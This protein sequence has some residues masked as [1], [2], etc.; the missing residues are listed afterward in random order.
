MKV[1]EELKKIR[2]LRRDKK[3]LEDFLERY[4]NIPGMFE[5]ST[6]EEIQNFGTEL[7]DYLPIIYRWDPD[8]MEYLFLRSDIESLKDLRD[9]YQN[10]E[11]EL[12]RKR[13]ESVPS[14]PIELKQPM[15]TESIVQDEVPVKEVPKVEVIEQPIVKTDI[16]L[17][18]LLD[19]YRQNGLIGEENNAILQTLGAINQLSFGIESLSGSGKS[20]TVDFLMKLLPE[21]AVYKMELS[22]N[23]A[24]M[25]EAETINQAKIICIPELQKAMKSSNPIVVEILKN[26]TEGKDISRK[27]RNQKE[28]T[29]EHY[30]INGDKGVIFTLAVENEFKYDAE[31][32]RRVFILHTDISQKQTDDI[33]R[34]KALKRHAKAVSETYLSQEEIK[35]LEE[36]IGNCLYFPSAEF[37]NPFAD[38]IVEFMPR[39]IRARSYDDYFFDLVD[40]CTKFNHEN[41]VQKDG[42]VFVELEDVYTVHKLYWKQFVKSLQNIPLLGEACL[43]EIGGSVD[44][45]AEDGSKSL[46]ADDVYTSLKR[47]YQ[48]V[49]YYVVEQTLNRL[50]DGGF[51]EM[52]DFKSKKP[53][54]SL[55]EKPKF[56]QDFDW[57]RCFEIGYQF[58]KENYPSVVDLWTLNQLSANQVTA[59]D[60]VNGQKTSLALTNYE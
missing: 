10:I 2:Q 45:V 57:Q 47:D 22:S 34:Y 12:F 41:R 29:N 18:T 60:P 59:L 1:T 27:V 6:H 43:N 54:Y 8:S 19:F 58:M 21:E 26:I 52:D 20:Y 37:E 33:L 36:H 17:K 13:V 15:E 5:D 53:R 35:G 56:S 42:V 39:T 3:S 44:D 25:Y 9:Q 7:S 4:Q 30:T 28:K 51:L 40:A 49:T 11:N 46:S 31:F 23:T 38:Y 16:T 48:T 14:E 32:S 55:L 24:E 50:V